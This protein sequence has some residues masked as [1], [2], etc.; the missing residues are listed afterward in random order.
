VPYITAR[1][2]LS[3]PLLVVACLFAQTPLRAQQAVLQFDAAIDIARERSQQ[4]VAERAAQAAAAEM[5]V[6]AGQRPDAMLVA[7]IEN[8]PVSGDDAF[9]VTR[10]S[11]TMRAIGIEFELTRGDRRDARTAR[12]AVEAEAAAAS[13]GA[14]LA[15][16]ERGTASAW[17]ERY[18]LEAAHRVLLRAREQTL[19][20][21]EAA[22]AAFRSGIGPESD[23]FAARLAV[24]QLDDRIDAASRDV[25]LSRVRLARWVGE[26]ASGPLGEPPAMDSA[27]LHGTDIDATLLHHPGLERLAR[28]VELAQ[29]EAEILRANQRSDWTVELMYGQRSPA[30]SN[31]MSFR[32]SK[33]LRL[34]AR[35]RQD[36][37]LAAQLALAGRASAEL[38]EEKRMHRAEIEALVA[39]WQANGSR[40]DRFDTELMPLARRGSDA[41]IA[42]Y[43]GGTGTLESVLDA[44]IAEID[45]ELDRVA[46][47]NETALIWAELYYLVPSGDAHE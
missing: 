9:E 15:A 19:L 40:L 11:M 4:L 38:E 14:A 26:V 34:N 17:L 35:D 45:I 3:L 24:A 6:A 8:L 25:A 7:G 29:A 31:M 41:A 5:A 36:R 33:P 28:Q 12:Y 39:A 1:Y 22:D 18:F 37:E 2:R 20:Q 44:R 10:D 16:L 23:A 21:V 13:E 43:R 30:Y 42:A 46:L 32:A 47:E 27:G